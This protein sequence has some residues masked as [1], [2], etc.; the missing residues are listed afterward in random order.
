[1]GLWLPC[2][3]RSAGLREMIPE[4]LQDEEAMSPESPSQQKGKG[5][6]CCGVAERMPGRGGRLTGWL[7]YD[8]FIFIISLIVCYSIMCVDSSHLRPGGKP[9]TDL[10][11]AADIA[12]DFVESAD[13]WTGHAAIYWARIVYAL[14]SFPFTFF[15]IPGLQG[16][17]TH[18]KTTGYNRNGVC[19]PYTV[20]S[21][22]KETDK[23]S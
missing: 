14:L 23:D 10:P 15:W 16:I 20:R 18:T 3:T 9:P 4:Q 5:T 1:M 19:V 13:R 2:S 12:E 7:R 11:G 21:L 8:F 17:L 6:G 22:P